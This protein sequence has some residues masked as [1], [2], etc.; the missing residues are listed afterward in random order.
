[1]IV[2]SKEKRRWRRIWQSLTRDFRIRNPALSIPEPVYIPTRSL[3][4][5]TW[6]EEIVSGESRD[7]KPLFVSRCIYSTSISGH[8]YLT[9]P[10]MHIIVLSRSVIPC[11]VY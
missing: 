4:K 8:G 3:E 2:A 9:L 5:R 1:M 6:L 11:A 7:L 10:C